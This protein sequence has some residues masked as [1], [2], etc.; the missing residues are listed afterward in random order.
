MTQDLSNLT[1][2]IGN[3]ESVEEYAAAAPVIR[4]TA[5]MD[6]ELPAAKNGDPIGPMA[7]WF[8]FQPQV[9][10]S[11]IGP[12]GHPKRGGFM[13]PVPL[14]RRMFGGARTT[15]IRPLRIGELMRRDGEITSVNIKEGRT[16]TL[17]FVTVKYSFY[18][19]DGLA[20]E[21]EHDIVYRDNPKPDTGDGR[22]GSGKTNPP[23][24]EPVWSLTVTPDPVMLFRY[25][26][27]T[28]NGH[29]IHYDRKYV[30]EVEGYP[31][32]IVHGPLVASWVLEC[33]L[34]NN[35]GRELA[36]FRFQARSPLFDV[37]PFGVGG[38]PG[39]DGKGCELWATTP[40]G[41]LATLA[42]A[43]FV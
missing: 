21:E 40:E 26:A 4:F 29:R 9:P 33:G 39:E 22:G 36:A 37:A 35:P 28:F 17:V 5:L 12:D 8:Y 32:L 3:S 13:P 18:G 41:N 6:N 14:P 30:T 10:A 38:V 34:R 24:S 1:D 20:M 11:E 2:W 43:T 15:Y 7:H 19:E 31:G 42:T 25:S 23:P 27:I 16:G